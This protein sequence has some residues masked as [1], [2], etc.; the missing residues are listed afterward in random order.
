[1]D[2]NFED[3]LDQCIKDDVS[4]KPDYEK[5]TYFLGDLD[6]QMTP[7]EFVNANDHIKFGDMFIV[8][9]WAFNKAREIRNKAEINSEGKGN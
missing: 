2:D 5:R 9:R 1:M 3:F 4:L 6:L 8:W 7:Y